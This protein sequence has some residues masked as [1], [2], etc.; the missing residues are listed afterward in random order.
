MTGSRPTRRL[1]AWS[2]KVNGK[3]VSRRLTERQA[4]LSKRW[5]ANDRQLRAILTKMRKI[6]AKSTELQLQEAADT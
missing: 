6:A 2:A 1:L 4:T 3:T 5:I